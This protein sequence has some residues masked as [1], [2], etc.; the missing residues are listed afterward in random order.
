MKPLVYLAAFESGLDLDTTVPDEPIEVPLGNDGGTKWIA[1]YDNQFKGPMPM[2]Q[3]LAESR[4]TVAVWL[5][6]EIGV[7]N[8]I[9][10]AR[11]MGI[12]TPLQPYLSAPRS[13][14]LKCACW[15]W[16]TSIAR[17]PRACWRSRTSSV[18]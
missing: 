5:T 18:A 10:T 12:R 13:A 15:N 2:R 8:V 4:N 17:S 1:N 14:P 3:A 7:S 16:L 6:R 11:Q 9:R